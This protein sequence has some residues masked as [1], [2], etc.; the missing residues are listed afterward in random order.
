M[1]DPRLVP[2][3]LEQADTA[4][5]ERFG[6][7][8]YGAL[9]DRE[10]VPLGGMHD[11]GAEGFDSPAGDPEF[12]ADEQATSFLQVS[13]Q[14]SSR[15]KIR[16][17]VRRL[18]E[19]G[20]NP[21]VVTY[22]T[23]RV[24]PDTD[25]EQNNL[26]RELDCNIRIR[27]AKFIEANINS[28]P[29]IQAA[30]TAY[31]LPAISY[32]LN[33]GA[34]ELGERASVYTDRT[35]A[36]FLRQEVDS[37]RGRGGLLE[38]VT[39]SLILWSLSDTDPDKGRFLDRDGI[40][41]RIEETLPAA[42]HFVRGVL[43]NRLVLLASKD[44]PGGRQI[45]WYRRAGNYCLPYE[46]RLLVAAENAED[47]VLKMQVSCL[48]ED[49]ITALGK[50]ELEPLREPILSTCHSTLER[51]FEHQGL[52]LSQFATN[53]PEDDE[54]FTDVAHIL[55]DLIDETNRAPEEKSLIR[56]A[57][58]K[59][60][61]KTFY[62][63][64]REERTYLQKLSRT[65]ILLLLIRNEPRIVEFF[66]SIA[67][68]LNLYVG[69]DIIIRALSEHFLSDDNRATVNLLR[70]LKECGSTLILT[71][72]V[73]E[74]VA[75][76]LRRQMIEFEHNYFYIE[77]KIELPVVD[78]IDRLLIR[79]YFRARLEPVEGTTPPANWREYM[80]N[81]G[82][83][84]DIRHNRGDR[85]L[86][87]YLVNKFGLSF[88][89]AE[90]MQLGLDEMEVEALTAEIHAAKGRPEGDDVLAYND[91]LHVLRVYRRRAD[92]K[93]KSPGN[94]F[95][96]KTWWLTQDGKVR[97]ASAR[98]VRNNAGAFFMMRPEFLINY[99]GVAPELD[100]VRRSFEKIF[101]T[102]LGV[103]LSARLAPDVFETVLKNAAEVAKVDDA[104]AAAMIT[105]LTDRLKS[106]QLRIYEHR[107]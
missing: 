71:E 63:S 43:D 5:F 13:K 35:L 62:E 82:N 6:Q 58:Q 73:V 11:G 75:T 65:Y 69:T 99:I 4:S 15:A 56:K 27:D 26:S 2:I 42:R 90:E 48:F 37:R 84:G 28:S 47:D 21:K 36:V 66:R 61:R 18:R 72:K 93:E 106:D 55:S 101:P 40:L 59:I 70:I 1:I 31:L 45:R 57:C 32:L 14:L 38:S 7:A 46:T 103:R 60:L 91:A 105:S 102:A 68:S 16:E 64:S 12:F 39:D 24:V 20:R 41:S 86:G 97:R 44:A 79:S 19:F 17:T 100:E 96:W 85:E 9:Q 51:V 53:G 3:A 8:F 107:W 10:F 30:F 78:Y 104:R 80:S 83:Y 22:L 95:G 87:R 76:H 98:V 23:S 92:D 74:E 34:S 81:F 54:L 89:S 33:P 88:E 52:K 67:K 77:N 49:R 50:E 94:P 29:S 25:V